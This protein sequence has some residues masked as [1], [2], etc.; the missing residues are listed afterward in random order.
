[1]NKIYVSAFLQCVKDT[2]CDC[3]ITPL[4]SLSGC[5]MLQ[6]STSSKLVYEIVGRADPLQS[7]PIRSSHVW[8]ESKITMSMATEY[9]KRKFDP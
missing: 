1:M 5:S 4:E 3:M 9:A 6:Q 7:I 8:D 2:Y